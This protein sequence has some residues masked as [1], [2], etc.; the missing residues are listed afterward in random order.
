MKEE[1]NWEDIS[2][3]VSSSYRERILKSLD[4][5]K[6][7]SSLSRELKINKAHISRALS[8]L[9]NK[10]MIECLTPKAK[11]GRIYSITEYGKKVLNGYS[12]L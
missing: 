12:K 3:I 9:E 1:T 4:K 5:P 8:E 10:K 11:K 6:T 7:P 2:F